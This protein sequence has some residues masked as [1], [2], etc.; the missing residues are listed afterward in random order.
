M[1][2]KQLTIFLIMLV[3]YALCAFATYAFSQINWPLP[4]AGPCQK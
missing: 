3:V 4:L 1:H 2:R